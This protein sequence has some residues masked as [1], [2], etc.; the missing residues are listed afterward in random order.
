MHTPQQLL[1][2]ECN[3]FSEWSACWRICNC[4]CKRIILMHGS[5]SKKVRNEVYLRFYKKDG[6]YSYGTGAVMLEIQSLI[7]KC[8]W[9]FW[10][11]CS[12]HWWKSRC[13]A[14]AQKSS[15]QALTKKSNLFW[16]ERFHEWNRQNHW[17]HVEM[18]IF[19]FTGFW[20]SISAT[21]YPQTGKAVCVDVNWLTFCMILMAWKFFLQSIFTRQKAEK[22]TA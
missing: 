12:I 15:Y 13:L 1:S 17:I 5:N 19:L 6:T 20:Y 10:R 7:Q 14:N 2:Q 22:S 16:T 9:P 21:A 8:N 4:Q 11:K 3:S 18:Y